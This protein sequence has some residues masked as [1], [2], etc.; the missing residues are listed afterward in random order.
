MKRPATESEAAA[1]EAIPAGRDAAHHAGLTYVSDTDP[2]FTR[3]RAGKGFVY[4]DQTGRTL[5]DRATLNR[6]RA[7]VIPP[8]WTEVWICRDGNGHLQATGR[9]ARGRKQYIYHPDFRSSREANKYESLA[10][11]A[12]LLPQIRDRLERDMARPG[13]PREKVLATI[14]HLLETT[15]IRIGNLD[16]AK[17]NGSYGI[18]TLRDHHVEANG[19]ELRFD[20]QGKSGKHWRLR[21]RD[22]R[23][24]KIVKACQDLPGQHLFQYLD[25]DGGRQSITSS[26]VNAYLREITGGEITAKDFRTWGGTLLAGLALQAFAA[27]ASR[28][29]ATR[30]LRATVMQVGERLGNTP[31]IC[32]KCYIHPAVIES[33]EAGAHRL[34]IRPPRGRAMAG[35]KPEEQALL[36]HLEA[37]SRRARR[38]AG[39]GSRQGGQNGRR[40]APA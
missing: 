36:A 2:G 40:G 31:T 15:L 7:L 11:F 6:L 33:Y 13:L 35:L 28:R 1:I 39:R 27:P 16:Y 23:I 25:A 32:R 9:D 21:L 34:K 18:T 5:R 3:R 4:C 14:V 30:N 37:A 10:A 17:Q 26:D 38:E 8:A 22:R 29:E 24:T 12:R 19:A 20:F